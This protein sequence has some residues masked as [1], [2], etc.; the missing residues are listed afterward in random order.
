MPTPAQPRVL[1]ARGV[2]SWLVGWLA[3]S[4]WIVGVIAARTGIGVPADV[5]QVVYWTGAAVTAAHFGLSYHLAYGGGARAVRAR[6]L[7]LAFGPLLLGIVLLGVVLVALHSGPGS[8]EN[9]ARA[10]LTSVYVMT[11]WHYIK[12]VYGV[13]R[14]GGAFA[15]VT[16]DA[17]DTRILRFG[18]YP[19]WFLGAAQVLVR[20][21]TYNLGGFPV[22]IGVLPFGTVHVLR[23]LVACSIVPIATVFVRMTLRRRALPPGTL[24][25]PY[26]ATFLWLGFPANPALTLLL[27]APF[28]ALQYL[29]VGHRAEIAVAADQPGRHGVMWW[30][31]IFAGATCLGLLLGRWLPGLLDARIHSERLLFGAAFFVFLNLHHYLIDASIWRS[32]GDLVRAMGRRRTSAP[33]A[34]QVPQAVVT[35]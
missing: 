12:Q 22:G 15:G 1:V 20:G 18:L 25:A 23:V 29:A 2:D 17:W 32:K 28:H 10:L 6:P 7:A 19:L 4:V 13:A 30:L 5:T 14:V 11:S 21:A 9:V 34:E 16:F 8:V 35:A 33:V 26:V 31:N 3:V 27:L 24:L